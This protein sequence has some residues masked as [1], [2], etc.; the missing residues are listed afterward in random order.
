MDLMR[1]IFNRG[2][3]IFLLFC[4]S[5]KPNMPEIVPEKDKQIPSSIKE[6]LESS[7]VKGQFDPETHPGFVQIEQK[8]ASRPGMWMLRDAYES[9]QK[10]WS[11][12][13][14]DGHEIR[15]VSA[16]RNFNAQKRIWE[17]KWTGNTILSDGT[18]ANEIEDSVLRAKKILLYSSMPGTSRHH[19][20]T[21]IDINH[22]NNEWFEKGK[23]KALYAWMTNNAAHYGFCQPYQSKDA[24]RTGYEEEKWHWSYEPISRYL[25]SYCEYAITNEAINGFL[26]SETAAD[27]NVVS[28]YILGVDKG[29]YS[30]Q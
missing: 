6:L 5:C 7:Y 30:A 9:F 14:E 1:N 3:V 19:W 4:T 20:G 18:K 28:N 22:L 8:Y 17:Q 15:I 23:G 21:D 11:A 25:T 16:T 13:Q 10:M 24:G 2:I 27:I 12:A 26:G 29:C